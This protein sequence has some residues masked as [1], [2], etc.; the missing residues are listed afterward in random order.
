MNFKDYACDKYQ[1]C[2]TVE[3][4][5]EMFPSRDVIAIIDEKTPM[6]FIIDNIMEK[7]PSAKRTQS[8]RVKVGNRSVTILR[9]FKSHVM[10]YNRNKTVMVVYP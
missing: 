1:W 6:Y 2:N 5:L 9:G 8:N 4:A 10:G 7:Y 3:A